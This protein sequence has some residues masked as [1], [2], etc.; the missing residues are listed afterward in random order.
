V[1]AEGDRLVQKWH[2]WQDWAIVVL[3]VILFLTPFA[4]RAT[5]MMAA[6]WAAYVGGVLLVILGVLD[7]SD[8]TNPAGEWATGVL[9]VLIFVSPWAL[10]F[11]ELTQMGW[12]A[13]IIGALSV[14]LAAS[15]VLFERTNQRAAVSH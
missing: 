13:W 1:R 4:F 7:L 15:V 5:S 12:S 3:G 10:G 8:P 14:V 2:R 6:A 11:S 9:G